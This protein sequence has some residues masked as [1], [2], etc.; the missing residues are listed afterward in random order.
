MNWTDGLVLGALD[1][2]SYS[3]CSIDPTRPGCSG[4]QRGKPRR[5]RDKQSRAH[6][7]TTIASS[8]RVRFICA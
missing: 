2:V 8:P 3:T 1:P 6:V 4:S 5:S 7:P